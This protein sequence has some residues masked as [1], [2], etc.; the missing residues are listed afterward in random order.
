VS[1]NDNC[2][3]KTKVTHAGAVVQV[4][5]G[6]LSATR[7]ALIAQLNEFVGDNMQKL[8]EM[9][10]MSDMDDGGK[11]SKYETVRIFI[12]AGF[13][14]TIEEMNDILDVLAQ[15]TPKGYVDYKATLK[16]LS[17]LTFDMPEIFE[18]LTSVQFAPT[19][20]MHV[21]GCR[22]RDAYSNVL[23]CLREEDSEGNGMVSQLAMLRI[24]K[25]TGLEISLQAFTELLRATGVKTQTSS[26]SGTT[27]L[28]AH[29]LIHR[30]VP[31]HRPPSVG[32]HAELAERSRVP[33]E[34]FLGPSMNPDQLLEKLKEKM[35]DHIKY[36]REMFLKLDTDRDGTLTKEELAPA[37]LHFN[38]YPKPS[39]VDAL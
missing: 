24:L 19:H 10:E 37:F 11:V 4:Y 2:H 32:R 16:K 34:I 39:D 9:F 12:A 20:L 7:I 17:S 25:G 22:I 36:P 18:S 27:Y 33:K 13:P 30:F 8:V 21:V 14:V 23:T 26:T 1:H 28:N 31:S 5:G 15:K 29:H 3:L 6:N 35:E 38:L